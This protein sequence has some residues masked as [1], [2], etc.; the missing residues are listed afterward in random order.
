MTPDPKPLP[1]EPMPDDACC[2]NGCDPCVL[3]FYQA[4]LDQYRASLRAWNQRQAE[5]AS[6]SEA[7]AAP[8]KPAS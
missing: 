6:A 5:R 3:D 4:E 7:A 2:G 1:P 8:V